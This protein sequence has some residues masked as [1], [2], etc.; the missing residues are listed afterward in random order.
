MAL[1]SVSELGV[2]ST[3]SNNDLFLVS[4]KDGGT[5]SS[6]SISYEKLKSQLKEDCGGDDT[7]GGF[8]INIL[9]DSQ[10]V[11]IKDSVTLTKGHW[12][13]CIDSSV[14]V[15]ITIG[16]EK[17]SVIDVFPMIN[18]RVGIFYLNK[19]CTLNNMWCFVGDES[20]DL[21]P[22]AMKTIP[23]LMLYDGEIKTVDY[24]GI[25]QFSANRIQI[26][27]GTIKYLYYITINIITDDYCIVY[28]P[29]TPYT[30]ELYYKY[31]PTTTGYETITE[32]GITSYK[33]TSSVTPG[34]T[35]KLITG[36]VSSDNNLTLSIEP[37]D[38]INFNSTFN[39]IIVK[40]FKFYYT[41]IT[42]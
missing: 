33:V 26:N 37:G 19:G 15:R 32:D 21:S 17:F 6:K 7:G 23:E 5:F 3:V 2:I 36:G 25:V 24:D 10:Y 35:L 8:D 14:E 27:R 42:L 11:P 28:V 9:D 22:S 30:V 4:Q 34:G 41:K 18:G 16:G 20:P 12:V 13:K 38:H 40:D 29:T 31:K 1:K 39:K